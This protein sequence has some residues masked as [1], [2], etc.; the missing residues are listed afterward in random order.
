MIIQSILCIIKRRSC[1]G[2]GRAR[3]QT[4]WLCSPSVM[5]GGI[6]LMNLVFDVLVE[7]VITVRLHEL[8]TKDV[9]LPFTKNKFPRYG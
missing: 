7:F 4:G 6:F 1:I 9:K 8:L 2:F 5:K 3:A